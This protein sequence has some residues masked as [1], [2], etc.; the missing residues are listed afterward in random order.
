MV[1]TVVLRPA[2]TIGPYLDVVQN[3]GS[4]PLSRR[5]LFSDDILDVTIGSSQSLLHIT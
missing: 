3:L 4:L 1:N 5:I 2:N